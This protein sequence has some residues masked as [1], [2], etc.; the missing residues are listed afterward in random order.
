MHSSKYSCLLGHIVHLLLHVWVCSCFSKGLA[1]FKRKSWCPTGHCLSWNAL[2]WIW[3]AWLSWGGKRAE[4]PTEHWCAE[5]EGALG[6]SK[7][8]NSGSRVKLALDMLNIISFFCLSFG[9]EIWFRICSQR[10]LSPTIDMIYSSKTK[11]QNPTFKVTVS[12]HSF[13]CSDRV[14]VWAPP[15]WLHADNVNPIVC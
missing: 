1:E 13:F 10:V 4:P 7:G 8:M 6:G 9:S 15:T 3:R 12:F 5:G 14:N 2:I 11:L